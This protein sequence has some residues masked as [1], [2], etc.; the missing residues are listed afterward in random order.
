MDRSFIVKSL[1]E[2]ERE[3][4]SILIDNSLYLELDLT[5]RYRLLRFLASSFFASREE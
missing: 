2:Q 1:P 5:E 4:I 3:I